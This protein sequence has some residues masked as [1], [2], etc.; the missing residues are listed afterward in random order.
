MRVRRTGGGKGR[1][2]TWYVWADRAEERG[3]M[4]AGLLEE[5]SPDA[6]WKYVLA[7][8]FG[9]RGAA[10]EGMKGLEAKV[11]RAVNGFGELG[12]GDGSDNGSTRK[13]GTSRSDED[14]FE[15]AR[16]ASRKLGI[17]WPGDGPGTA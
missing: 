4:R 10:R 8:G 11:G 13:D 2:A 6:R 12:I 3:A 14:V 9:T 5:R 7:W 16:R 15:S 17:S 1:K